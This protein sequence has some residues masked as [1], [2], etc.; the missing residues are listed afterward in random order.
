MSTEYNDTNL[1]DISIDNEVIKNIALKAAA[2]T[3][4]IHAIRKGF[5]K[6]I[7]NSLTKRDSAVGVKL[8]FITVSEVKITLKLMIEYGVNIPYIAGTVQENVKSVV[9][10]MTGLAVTEV[11]VK[12][13]GIEIKKGAIMEIDATERRCALSSDATV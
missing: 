2:D 8:E 9:E 13:V 12:I 7:W 3:K 1:G 11:A 4:G 5:I 6:R 10:Y